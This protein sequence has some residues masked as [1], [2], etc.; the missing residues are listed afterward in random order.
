MAQRRNDDPVASL[1]IIYGIATALLLAVIV[2]ALNA[3]FNRME[4]DEI[5]R[6]VVNQSPEELGRLVAEQQEQLNS[7]RWV[8]PA[9]Q[10]A[11]IP[12][13]RAME[14]VTRELNA[15]STA[16]QGTATTQ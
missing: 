16:A 8:D 15:A 12:I 5:R 13:D 6:K 3:F 1:T 4:S 7:Y 10:V 11:A 14:I 9:K 2:I